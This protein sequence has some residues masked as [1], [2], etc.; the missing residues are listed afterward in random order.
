MTKHAG[1]ANDLSVV[2]EG[3]IGGK[4][5][6][7]AMRDATEGGVLGGA[8]EMAEACGHGV[9]VDRPLIPV[10]AATIAICAYYG[11]DDLRLIFSGITL[12]T[13]EGEGFCELLGRLRSADVIGTRIGWIV[14]GPSCVGDA[15]GRHVLDA[16]GADELYRATS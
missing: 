15:D 12:I 2:P 3:R 8:W 6:V 7:S 10:E 4:L 14:D 9:E 1:F 16:P 11:L 5:G 13:M